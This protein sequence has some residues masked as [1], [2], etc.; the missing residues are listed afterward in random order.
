MRTLRSL[1]LVALAAFPL[2]LAAG[3]GHTK[4]LVPVD[5]PLMPWQA[6]EDLQAPDEAAPAAA[7]AVKPEA[8]PAGK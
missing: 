5:S 3:C 2:A 7:P 1:S 8:K 4:A 6:P